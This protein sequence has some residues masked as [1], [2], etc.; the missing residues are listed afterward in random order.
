MDSLN[1]DLDRWHR[2]HTRQRLDCSGLGHLWSIPV[3]RYTAYDHWSP[4]HK[5]HDRKWPSYKQRSILVPKIPKI[6]TRYRL[7]AT[8][9]KIRILEFSVRNLVKMKG[10]LHYVA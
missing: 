1:R 9:T 6:A 7:S 2:V 4:L 5:L 10:D 3:H 8:E